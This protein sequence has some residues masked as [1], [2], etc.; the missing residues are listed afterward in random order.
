MQAEAEV[1]GS[2]MARIG[3]KPEG[4]EGAKE[5]VNWMK[6]LC[7]VSVCML[8]MQVLNLFVTLLK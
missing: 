2:T 6:I 3:L 1:G 4:S 8:L 5:V 7:V